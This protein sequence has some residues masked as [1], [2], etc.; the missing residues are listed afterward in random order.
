MTIE[1]EQVRL[2][3]ICNSIEINEVFAGDEG[4]SVCGECGT[5]EGGSKYIY[6]DED[7]YYHCEEDCDK[8]HEEIEDALKC[9][10]NENS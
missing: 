1:R 7:D 6:E 8:K 10:C 9:D 5:I 3:A 4:W 2:C